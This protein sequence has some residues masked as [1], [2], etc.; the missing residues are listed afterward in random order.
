MKSLFLVRHAKSSWEA[1][2]LNDFERPLNERGKKDAPQMAK[3]LFEDRFDIDYF[4]S[5]PAKRA[6]T[7][8]EFFADAYKQREKIIYIDK[9]YEA[10][11]PVFYEVIQEINEGYNAVAIF[12]HN[13]GIT[14]FINS[15]SVIDLDEM[16]TCAI[17][18]LN[19]NSNTW[20]DFK[21]AAKELLFFRYPKMADW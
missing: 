20:K 3:K 19:I 1:G 21:K 15:L 9:L 18:G 8:A 10:S 12:S 4:I 6:K 13:P 14:D 2:S 17:V 5:S 7:T 16:P 11:V